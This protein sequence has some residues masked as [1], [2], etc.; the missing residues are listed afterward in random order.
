MHR[1]AERLTLTGNGY[2]K[3]EGTPGRGSV[4]ASNARFESLRSILA[5]ALDGPGGLL[6]EIDLTVRRRYPERS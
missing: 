1:P 3:D 2:Y 5:L 6:S 4:Q